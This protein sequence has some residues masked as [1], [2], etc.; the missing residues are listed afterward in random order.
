[1]VWKITTSLDGESELQLSGVDVFT[2][3]DDSK[4]SSLIAYWDPN[5]LTPV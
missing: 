3:T 2:I 5:R 4:I 1:M